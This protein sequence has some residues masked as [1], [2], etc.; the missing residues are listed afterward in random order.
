MALRSRRV[1]DDVE[2]EDGQRVLVERLW[3]R[4]MKKG[5]PRIGIWLKDVAP[6]TELRKEFHT[7]GDYRD[8]V[9]AY[10]KELRDNPAPLEELRRIVRENTT[11]TLVYSAKDTEHNSATVLR[12]LLA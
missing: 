7:R 8:F 11:V 10:R 4:G 5:D 12:D 6:S 1:Y 3:P 9:K 2:D